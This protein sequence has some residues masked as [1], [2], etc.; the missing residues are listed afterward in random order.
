MYKI[1][2]AHSHLPYCWEFHCL[3]QYGIY[4][5]TVLLFKKI[6]YLFILAF[7]PETLHLLIVLI[8]YV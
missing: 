6:K 2:T 3:L 5:E 4:L 1:I 7:L 8:Q